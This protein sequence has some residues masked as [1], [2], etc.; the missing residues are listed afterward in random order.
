MIDIDKDGK[1]EYLYYINQYFDLW[2]ESSENIK[3]EMEQKHGRRQDNVVIM[4]DDYDEVSRVYC[5]YLDK[6]ISGIRAGEDSDIELKL[7][8]YWE[9]YNCS[10]YPEEGFIY[11]VTFDYSDSE[12]VDFITEKKWYSV[13]SFEDNSICELAFDKNNKC[14]KRVLKEDG[15]GFSEISSEQ[16]DYTYVYDDESN[17]DNLYLG[18]SGEH[19]TISGNNIFKQHELEEYETMYA[20]N[21]NDEIYGSYFIRSDSCPGYENIVN[22]IFEMMN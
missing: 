3:K 16:Y 6:T 22:E 2:F 15:Q 4:I 9:T 18:Q 10:E 7:D 17:T 8:E 20:N 12:M 11:N 13:N 1:D 19:Y 14:T 5:I 21:D